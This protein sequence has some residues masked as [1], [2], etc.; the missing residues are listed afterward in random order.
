MIRNPVS[1]VPVALFGN[2]LRFACERGD[3]RGRIADCIPDSVEAARLLESK[4]CPA[5][6]GLQ[7]F[8]GDVR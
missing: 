2:P 3:H 7:A 1:A 6:L 4:R 8:I 5:Q